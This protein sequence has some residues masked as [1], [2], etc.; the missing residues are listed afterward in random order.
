MRHAVFW[1]PRDS[2]II[3]D[4]AG[5]RVAPH[6]IGSGTKPVRNAWHLTNTDTIFD[7]CVSVCVKW[8]ALSA[9]VTWFANFDLS[10]GF[11][12]FIRQLIGTA[13]RR[14]GAT[15]KV[16]PICGAIRFDGIPKFKRLILINY[17]MCSTC[18]DA[19]LVQSVL[20]SLEITVYALEIQH[21]LYLH[22]HIK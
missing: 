16:A 5:S 2:Q 8:A 3:A 6:G 21:G 14:R 20:S 18:V 19:R 15:G 13:R 7:V 17:R 9:R 11:R 4:K 22:T 1:S 12:R 10:R